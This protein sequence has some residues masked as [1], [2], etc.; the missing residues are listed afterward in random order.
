MKYNINTRFLTP[1]VAG[2]TLVPLVLVN[3]REWVRIDKCGTMWCGTCSV[4]GA[5]AWAIEKAHAL[6]TLRVLCEFPYVI[7]Q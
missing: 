3:V 2:I 4:Y 1:S 5:S 6:S 7:D